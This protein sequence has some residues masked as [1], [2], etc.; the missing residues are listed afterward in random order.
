MKVLAERRG[1]FPD[2]PHNV[3]GLVYVL[4]GRTV[5]EVHVDGRQL[6]F[7]GNH[8]VVACARIVFE[9]KIDL[10]QKKRS[11]PSDM[12]LTA[13]FEVIRSTPS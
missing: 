2:I 12:G 13:G 3:I 8:P 6:W 7:V 10:S 4:D 5:Q 11:F 9:R 1:R